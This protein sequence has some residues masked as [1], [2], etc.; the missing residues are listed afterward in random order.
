L[1]IPTLW[2]IIWRSDGGFVA[3]INTILDSNPWILQILA[4][5]VV[6]GITVLVHEF[7]HFAMAK[8]LKIRVLVFSLGFG[9]KLAGF[10]RGGTEYRL[11]PIPVGGYVKMAGEAFDE[12]RKGSPDEFQSHPKS[13]RFLVAVSGPFMNILLAVFIMT[14]IFFFEGITVPRYTKEPA[15]VGPVAANSIAKKSGLQTGDRIISVQ[16]SSVQT[17]KDLELAFLTASKGTLNLGI[18]RNNQT[19]Q[20]YL[21]LPKTGEPV[22][23]P[24]LGFKNP[25]PKT[26]VYAVDKDSPAQK[27]GLKPGDEILSVA[28]NNRVGQGYDQILNIISESKG[29]SLSFQVRRP[30]TELPKDKLWDASAY[31][32]TTTIYLTISPIE[33]KGHV[34][35]GFL[36]YYPTDFERF[37]I[38]GAAVKS[39]QYNY[40]QSSLIFKVIGRMIKGSI[41]PRNIAGPIGIAQIAG[42]VARTL[43]VRAFLALLALISLNLGIFNLLPIPILDGGVIALL[44]IEG[45]IGREISLNLKEKIL[46]VGF[47]FLILLMGFVFFNDLS[48]TSVFNRLFR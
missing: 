30:D 38:A 26:I 20:I 21:D 45:V 34:I 19:M 23:P 5:V 27:A 32:K 44:F 28:G 3:L 1:S 9:P 7:G 48:K 29:I 6:L 15:I 22:E 16:G 18:I 31:R 4:F 13:H 36:P 47:V 37:G 35:I 24:S 46:Q 42:S 25:L 8:L 10:T 39:V 11:S 17:W 14:S 2:G 33:E 40:E 41:S 43:D 12:E